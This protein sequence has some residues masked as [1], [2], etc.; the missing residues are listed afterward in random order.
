MK[1]IL[2]AL[3][4][5]GAALSAIAQEKTTAVTIDAKGADVRSVIH[6]IFQQT[7]KN[8]VLKP[9]VRFV[10]YLSLDKVNFDEALAIVCKNANLQFEVQ[11]DIYYISQAPIKPVEPKTIET[12]P[13]DQKNPAKAE[14]V[15]K[16]AIQ[17]NT[18][19]KPKKILPTTVLAKRVTTRFTK[20]DLREVMAAFSKQTGV[21]IE[22]SEDVPAY[23][24]DAYLI[25][26]SLKYGLDRITE[27]A[28][29]GYKFTDQ[30][31]LLIS[32]KN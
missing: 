10:L 8:F 17:K 3:A 2:L 1:R 19:T 18:P 26:T 9:G 14:I 25:N 21:P 32:K 12:K 15:T 5:A 24:L 11:N 29:L 23:K 6:D 30:G 20:T 28:K 13:A 7:G 27:A 22:V 4:L 31:T 16:V